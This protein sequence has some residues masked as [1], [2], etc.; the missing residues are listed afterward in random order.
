[1]IIATYWGSP[2]VIGCVS[3]LVSIHLYLQ[4]R[5]LRVTQ[6]LITIL[7]STSTTFFIKYI[8]SR[9]RPLEA[10]Y[11]ES[12]PSFP[13]GH[14]ALSMALYGFLI[15]L[16]LRHPHRHGRIF[17]ITLLVSAIILIGFSRVYLGVHYPSD[18][19]AGYVIGFMWIFLSLPL[20]KSK[21]WHL[22]GKKRF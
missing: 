13:S 2:M 22:L 5:Y 10:F 20:S 18:V 9:E 17:L 15:Y 6:L 12:T 19:M 14:A 21:I 16:L 3:A 7:G 11:L 8:Y 1:M 4:K